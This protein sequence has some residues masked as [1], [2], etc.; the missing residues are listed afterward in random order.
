MEGTTKPLTLSNPST[1]PLPFVTQ[2]ANSASS[3]VSAKSRCKTGFLTQKTH[4]KQ[5]I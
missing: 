5:P 2:L 4:K 1:K 3:L